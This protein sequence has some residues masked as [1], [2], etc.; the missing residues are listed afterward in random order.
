MPHLVERLARQKRV[1]GPRHPA[2]LARR[3]TA[4]AEPIVA[5]R[6]LGRGPRLDRADGAAAV[7]DADDDARRP[8]DRTV[9]LPGWG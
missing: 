3:R 6:G 2:E 8:D 7:Q 1:A 4:G 9:G 5:A